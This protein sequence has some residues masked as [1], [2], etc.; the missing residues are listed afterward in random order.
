M[1][2]F[3]LL[4]I[5]EKYHHIRQ[6]AV[7]KVVQTVN[8]LGQLL[9]KGHQLWPRGQQPQVSSGGLVW[10]RVHNGERPWEINLKIGVKPG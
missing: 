3:P 5:V 6:V 2:C 1:G 8:I 4:E 7:F 10:V 9:R